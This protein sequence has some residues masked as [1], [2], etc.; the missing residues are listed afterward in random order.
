MPKLHDLALSKDENKTS[1][2]NDIPS[3]KVLLDIIL[4]ISISSFV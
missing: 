3:L 1:N 4:L 2:L